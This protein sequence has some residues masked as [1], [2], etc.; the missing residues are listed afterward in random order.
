MGF[1]DAWQN[2]LSCKMA[3]VS[4][5]LPIPALT[6]GSLLVLGTP[7][8]YMLLHHGGTIDENVQWLQGHH[9]PAAFATA[10]KEQWEGSLHAPRAD[11]FNAA[12]AE[13][14]D[15]AEPQLVELEAVFR[16]HGRGGAVGVRELPGAL[17]DAGVFAEAG[18]E[19]GH[20]AALDMQ[21]LIN[22][23]DRNE[24]GVLD[25]TEFLDLA[26]T[27]QRDVVGL[28]EAF[29]AFDEDEDGEI[30][31]AA[32]SAQSELAGAAKALAELR[33]SL[34]RGGAQPDFDDAAKAA[35]ADNDGKLN[36]A[37][38]ARLILTEAS[39]PCMGL[40]YVDKESLVTSILFIPLVLG[41]VVS[42][43][44]LVGGQQGVPRHAPALLLGVLVC[45]VGAM[46]GHGPVLRRGMSSTLAGAIKWAG[47]LLPAG[48]FCS[49]C[50]RHAGLAHTSG[51]VTLV[52]WLAVL[53]QLVDW[54]YRHLFRSLLSH[55]L[56]GGV[57][58]ILLAVAVPPMLN[59][60][61]SVLLTRE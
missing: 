3:L 37:E 30:S 7:K 12:E 18:H 13:H 27:K 39:H 46:L 21:S 14:L 34:R 38:F 28:R 19:A 2:K 9:M 45:Y 56:V 40:L 44:A 48:C 24:N 57:L 36:R 51:L 32:G 59:M 25:Q 60:L 43:I 5:L 31:Y 8:P 4:L 20:E 41:V 58:A 55:S 42:A 22:R 6:L 35:D 47:C 1:T 10:M 15:I 16:R 23:W 61:N 49:E 54:A 29:D 50:F 17:R 53:A 11:T 33:G 26:V 52:A